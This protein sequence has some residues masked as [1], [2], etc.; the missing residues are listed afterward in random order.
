M[1]V[2][3]STSTLSSSLQIRLQMVYY[4]VRELD[5]VRRLVTIMPARGLAS[6]PASRV[7]QMAEDRDHLNSSIDRQ[8][9]DSGGPK[10]MVEFERESRVPESGTCTKCPQQLAKS[11]AIAVCEKSWQC[12]AGHSVRMQ[13]AVLRIDALAEPLERSPSSK[14]YDILLGSCFR[15]AKLTDQD[16]HK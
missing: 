13:L 1:H 8:Q 15:L 6:S 10:S 14:G 4:H 9:S 5:A 7:R 3:S 12:L 11:C 16:T 2:V